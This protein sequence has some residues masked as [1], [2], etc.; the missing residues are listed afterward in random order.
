MSIAT[1][2][3]R[4]QRLEDRNAV[5]DLAI[6]YARSIDRAD[7][8]AYGALFTDPVHID[9][10]DAGLPAADFPL[11]Q[12]VGFAAQNL[13]TWDARQHLSTNH[14]VVLDEDDPDRAVCHSYMYAQHHRAGTPVY[15][16]R[17][18]YEHHVVR[19]CG[20][21]KIARV[22]QHLSWLEGSPTEAG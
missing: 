1:L 19:A 7:W 3:R 14:Q 9:F 15:L 11:E 2:E 18:W 10:S 8:P 4:L 5:I 17:G 22:V 16:M 20:T 21:W 13:E 12:F 6:E